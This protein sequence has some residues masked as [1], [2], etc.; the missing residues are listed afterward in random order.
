MSIR[1]YNGIVNAITETAGIALNVCSTRGDM[2]E[3]LMIPRAIDERTQ[4]IPSDT[5][6]TRYEQ[7]DSA[8]LTVDCQCCYSP[9]R[10][11]GRRSDMYKRDISFHYVTWRYCIDNMIIRKIIRRR[12]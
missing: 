2:D 9:L 8:C 7:N 4:P 3:A 1:L 5:L 12:D 11:N 10:G 6:L